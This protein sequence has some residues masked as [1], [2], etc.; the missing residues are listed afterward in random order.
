MEKWLVAA[1]KADF[2]EWSRKFKIDQ[3]LARIIRNR[4]VETQEA[5]ERFL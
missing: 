1:K 3:V 2:Q 5:V 4:D